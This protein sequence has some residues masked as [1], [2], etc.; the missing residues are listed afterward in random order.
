MIVKPIKWIR[1]PCKNED[2]ILE[3]WLSGGEVGFPMP[4]ATR[5]AEHDTVTFHSEQ[6]FE[7]IV[8]A[9]TDIQIFEDERDF[10]ARSKNS[11][12]PEAFV[13]IG[14]LPADN[15]SHFLPSARAMI[16]GRVKTYADPPALGFE[17]EDTIFSMT[18]LGYQFDVVVPGT[19]D[20]IKNLRIGS[21]VSGIYLVHGWPRC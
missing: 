20:N 5:F 14:L 17:A 4:I 3:T 8:K 9:E 11:F 6:D 12:A 2:G 7:I 18:S 16:N 10:R 21:I 1:A 19:A 13:P 15:S